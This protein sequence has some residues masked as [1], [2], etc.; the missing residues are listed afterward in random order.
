[1]LVNAIRIHCL[2][3]VGVVLRVNL[4]SGALECVWLLHLIVRSIPLFGIPLLSFTL[5]S[6]ILKILYGGP[7]VL[8]LLSRYLFIIYERSIGLMVNLFTEY[9]ELI[10]AI[11]SLSIDGTRC[12]SAENRIHKWQLLN[13]RKLRHRCEKGTP[14][15]RLMSERERAR[16]LAW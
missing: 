5:L 8:S 3:L 1:V 11:D 12:Q 2:I 6:L 7:G 15:L 4:L 14:I 13:S 9:L 10:S 16:D